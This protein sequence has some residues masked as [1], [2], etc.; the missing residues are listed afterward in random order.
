METGEEIQITRILNGWVIESEL[1]TQ[2]FSS[3]EA[4]LSFLEKIT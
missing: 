3:Q 4:L 1:G 2:F